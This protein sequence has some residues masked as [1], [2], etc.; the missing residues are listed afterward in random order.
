MKD[1]IK[2]FKTNKGYASMKE[3]KKMNIHTRKIANAV[4]DEVIEKIKPGLYK[5]IN[6]SWDEDGSFT[7]IAKANKMAVICLTSASEY[8]KFTTYNP[9]IITVAVPNNTDKFII[10]YPPIKVYYF[11]NR[12]YENGIKEI[13]TKTGIFK[14]YS[15]EKTI[16]DLFRY[17]KKIGDDLFIE[18]L[19]NYI[20]Q[21]NRNTNKLIY[22]TEINK[23]KDK[24][25]PYIKS[26]V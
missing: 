5:L 17:R 24:I 25:M 10:N 3:F 12:F 16:C 23:I 1:I 7:D 14:I 13:K 19:K 6:F 8:Y 4:S 22:C 21:N 15:K 20:K 11:I 2:I 18:S 26:I 9:S